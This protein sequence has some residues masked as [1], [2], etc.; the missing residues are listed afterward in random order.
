MSP[1]TES[2]FYILWINKHDSVKKQK[3][4]EYRFSFTAIII[5]SHILS[6]N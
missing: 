2:V 1:L 3:F 5:R 6:S 4:V